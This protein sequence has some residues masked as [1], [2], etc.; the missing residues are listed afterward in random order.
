MAVA[1]DAVG[2]SASGVSSTASTTLAWSHTVSGTNT[3]LLA[4]FGVGATGNNDT[5]FT[6]SSVTYGAAAMT[7]VSSHESG[8]AAFGYLA[9]YKKIGAATGTATITVTMNAAPTSLS[10]GS[11]SFNGADQTTGV[12]S[13]F[14]NF[15]TTG[16]PTVNATTNTNGNIIAGMAVNGSAFGTATAP[17]TSRWINA[18]GLTNNSADN[19]AG[20]TSPATGSSVTMAWTSTNDFWAAIALEVLSAAAGAVTGGKQSITRQAV[21]RA[22]LW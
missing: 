11:M 22:S 1:F 2:P 3:L 17:S 20:A 10:G 13:P 12:G 4:A 18:S 16:G 6:V 8:N 9:V 7:L 21:K 14:T 19:S 5:G 15:S